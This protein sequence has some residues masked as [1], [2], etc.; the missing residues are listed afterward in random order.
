MADRWHSPEDEVTAA[1][2]G[3]SEGIEKEVERLR[4]LL[5]GKTGEQKDHLLEAVLR[6][7]LKGNEAAHPDVPL[8]ND[9]GVIDAAI[10]WLWEK[11]EKAHCPY[12]GEGPWKVEGPFSILLDNEAALSPVFTVTCANCGQTAFVKAAG[13][14]GSE[15]DGT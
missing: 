6:S 7:L 12:C 14:L 5:E 1:A 4:S 2:S 10:E 3:T 13:V 15:A 11:W 8:V 9:P